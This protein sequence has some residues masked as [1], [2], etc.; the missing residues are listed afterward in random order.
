MVGK[1]SGTGKRKQRKKALHKDFWMEVRKSRARFISIFCIVALGVAFF[2]GIQAASPDMRLSGDAY[3]NTSKLMDLKIVGTMGLT[4]DDVKAV[5]E[6][7]GVGNVEGAYSTDVICGENDSQKVLHVESLNREVNQLTL[8]EGRLPEKSGECFL[9]ST[10]AASQGYEVGSKLV[11][12]QDGDNG[13]L[14]TE[15]YTVTGIGKSPLYISFNRGNTTVGSGEVNGFAYVLQDDFDSEV[16][17]QI[18]VRANEVEKVTSYTDAYENLIDKIQKKVEGIEAECCQIRY[19]EVMA[20]AQDKISDA[21]KELE[22]GKK[23]ADEKLAD[24]KKKLDDGEKE[25]EDG[26]K[27]YNDGTKQLEDARKELEDGKKQ[28]ADAKKQIS[29]GRSQI[30]SAKEEAADGRSQLEDAQKKLDAG[31]KKYNTGKMK[32][33]EGKAKFDVAKKEFEAGKQK[34]ADAKAELDK[35]QQE[36]TAAIAQVKAGQTTVDT[37]IAQLNTQIPQL[38]AGISQLE[39][40]AAGLTGAQQAADA[41]QSAVSQAQEAVNAAQAAYDEAKQKADSGDEEA[42]AQLDALAQNL[43]NAQTALGEAD[44]A[45]K[46]AQ[47]TLG[48]CQQAAAQKTELEN[49]LAAANSGL[50][51]LQAKKTELAGTLATLNENQKQLDSGCATLNAQE[52]KLAPA[53]KEIDANEKTLAASKKQLDASLKKLESS[54][55]KLD[56]NRAK[57]DSADAQIAANEAKLNSGEAEIAANEKKL[58][59]GEKEIKENEEKLKDSEQKLKDARKELADGKK[60]YEDGKK[61]AQDEIKDGQQKIDD[62]KNELNDLEKPEWIIT[63]RNGLPEYSDYGDN[64]DRIKNIGEVFPVIFFLVAALISLTTMTRMVEEQRTQIGTMKALGYSKIHIASKYLSYAFLATAGG[65][66][67]GILIGEK[68]LPF[69][70]IKGYGMMYHNVDKTLQIHYELKY[71]LTASVAALICTV[72]ATVF[73]CYRAL[74]ETPASLMRPPAPKEGRRILLERMPFLWKHLNFTW[75]SSLRNLFRYKKRLFMTVFGIAGSMA[76]MLVG[77]GIRDSISDIVNLQYTDLQHYDAMIISDDDATDAEKKELQSYL[78]QNE[79][80]DHYTNIQL[81]KLTAPN[82]KSN[83]SVYVYVPEDLEKFKKDVTLQNRVTKQSYELPEEGAAVSEKTATLLDLK[84]GDELTLKKDDK[85]YKV[86]ISVITENYAGHYAYMSPQVY[87]ETFGEKPDYSDIVFTVKDKYK[88][89]LEEIG[90]K[91]MESPAVLSISYT[92]STVDMVE[93]MLS[94][95]GSVIVVLIVSAGMLAF[96]VLYNLNNINITERQRELATLK[97]LGFF[98]MEVSQYVMRENILLTIAGILAGSG[99]GI[100]LHR[101]IIMTIEVDAVMFGRNIRPVS[102]L[103][104]AALTCIFSVIV[105]ISMH[106]K[107]KK[108]DMVESLKSVE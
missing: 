9:D 87:E 88:D 38:E 85:E 41:A 29:D 64:A 80:L 58:T 6:L 91:I 54:Q 98:D 90:Q 57:L 94:T 55:R 66:I 30:A 4:E 28:L 13:L 35:K 17:T 16:F 92:S 23:E 44:H 45:L 50:A 67:V 74:A 78:E 36:L 21:E 75:K 96:V 12:R 72:G 52:E 2:S 108:I 49:N 24:A 62:A 39:A 69:I 82:G 8:T 11:I 99:V 14:K 18:Y 5:Q 63:D 84:V 22:D 7:S 73:S 76:L 19:D 93:R 10:F 100:L 71:A 15:E 32:Y 26:E 53:Q 83:L 46:T 105:N 20:E 1:T 25:L 42:K 34:L 59:D 47:A 40:A 31:W 103:Y 3:Y 102:F 37:Q 86:K 51:T 68:I 61:D 81:T 70:I 33:D 104:C 89:Q 97:V 60:D 79:D 43:G 27:K 101:Y 107:L 106:N 95:L 65:S 56:A 48:A 77:Y